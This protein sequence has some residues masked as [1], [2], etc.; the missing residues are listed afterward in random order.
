MASLADSVLPLIRTRVDL[1]RWSA[2]N[3]H[4]R[5]MHE[6]LDVLEAAR[7]TTDPREFYRLVNA[8]LTSAIKVIARADE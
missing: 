8:A 3:G 1:H 7:S 4:G 5:Q 2:A 6:A